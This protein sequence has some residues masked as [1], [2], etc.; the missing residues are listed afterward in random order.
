MAMALTYEP[1]PYGQTIV[2]NE[3]HYAYHRAEQWDQ[4]PT[5]TWAP[6]GFDRVR[7]YSPQTWTAHDEELIQEQEVEFDGV[8]SVIYEYLVKPLTDGLSDGVDYVMN[9]AIEVDDVYYVAD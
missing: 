1:V 9:K 2:D 6:G 3:P 4:D 8:F 5:Q 7:T